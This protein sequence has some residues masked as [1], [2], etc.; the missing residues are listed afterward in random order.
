MSRLRTIGLETTELHP[1]RFDGIR[2]PLLVVFPRAG[3]W[4]LVGNGAMVLHLL[5]HRQKRFKL[6]YVDC[7]G[8]PLL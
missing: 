3:L 4:Y 7:P 5:G 6:G 8:L 2:L 1:G